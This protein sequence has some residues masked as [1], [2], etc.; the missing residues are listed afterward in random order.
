MPLAADAAR[1]RLL[2]DPDPRSGSRP[3]SP[4]AGSE[5]T[6]RSPAL[7]PIAGRR[8]PLP[9]LLGTQGAASGSATGRRW[10]RGLDVARRPGSATGV[11]LD[12]GDGLRRRTAVRPWRSSPPTPAMP[13]DERA[14]RGR[15]PG[16]G[17][18]QGPAVGRQ[19]VGH[20]AGPGQAAGQDDRLGGDA[21]CARHDPRPAVRPG[22]PASA[23]RRSTPWC[24]TRDPEALR[25]LRTRFGGE[26][27]P[28]RPPGHRPGPRRARRPRG[29]AAAG[30]GAPRPPAT[31]EPVRDAADRAVE[32]IGTD[33]ARSRP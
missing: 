4:W 14:R 19:V 26:T 10:P 23:S 5:R 8:G 32:A 21:A 11:L 27:D 9:R 7:L 2:K 28:R 3:S 22:R 15:V 12:A 20:P 25:L 31:A 30:R 13:A 29:A 1:S 24:E 18:P 6:P 17:P 33:R 16:R